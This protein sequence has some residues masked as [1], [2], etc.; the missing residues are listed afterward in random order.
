MQ[1]FIDACSLSKK[2]FHAVALDIA[3]AYDSIDRVSMYSVFHHVGLTGSL[4]RTIERATNLS[5]T[6]L[7]TDN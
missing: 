4:F 6:Y 5:E 7:A 2:K 1:T 3:K